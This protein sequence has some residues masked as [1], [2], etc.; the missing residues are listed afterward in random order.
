MGRF[1]ASYILVSFVI[2][3]LLRILQAILLNPRH[4][5]VIFAI[6]S[7]GHCDHFNMEIVDLLEVNW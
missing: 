1:S 3:L 6:T 5:L 2:S 7:A 4:L